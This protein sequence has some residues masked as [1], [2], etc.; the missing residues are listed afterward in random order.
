MDFEILTADGD[1][2]VLVYISYQLICLWS[3]V[4]I[5]YC[6]IFIHFIIF[7]SG[8]SVLR[9][10]LVYIYNP[11]FIL[12]RCVIIWRARN[13]SDEFCLATFGFTQY[14]T[15]LIFVTFYAYQM[16]IQS[17]C[18]NTFAHVVLF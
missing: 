2:V 5:F 16:Q 14:Y 18:L 10:I 13:L 4:D 9:L 15:I 17:S 7:L 1:L 6:L 8:K 12:G 11:I 3:Q